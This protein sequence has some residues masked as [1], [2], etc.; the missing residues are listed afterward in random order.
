MLDQF[1]GYVKGRW[2]V[3]LLQVMNAGNS[4]GYP[5]MVSKMVM[6]TVDAVSLTKTVQIEVATT[7]V[8]GVNSYLVYTVPENKFM[9]LKQISLYHA[10]VYTF[11]GWMVSLPDKPTTYRDVYK[12]A[13]T[14]VICS[15][16]LD[17]RLPPGARIAFSVGAYT[18]VGDTY[19]TL[20]FDV[21]D[22]T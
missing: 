9:T 17:L 22:Y 15:T 10:G 3:K 2:F 16:G 7:G 13:A 11:N 5:M 18:S 1:I 21:E 19:S 4:S 14:D 8:T 20:F 6:P 12:C